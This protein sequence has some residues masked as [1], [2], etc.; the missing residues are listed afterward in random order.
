M[1]EDKPT[2]DTPDASEDGVISR[3]LGWPSVEFTA[4]VAANQFVMANGPSGDVVLVF[5][6]AALPIL[7]GETPEERRAQAA[8]IESVPVTT[9]ARVSLT[10]AAAE[11]LRIIV[12]QHLGSE[13][14]DDDGN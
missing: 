3:P 1:T 14:G 11:M 7:T 9:V 13:E 8:A 4:P 10:H 12:N 5:G 6:Y 2:A